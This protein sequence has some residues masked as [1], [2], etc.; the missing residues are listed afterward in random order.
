VGVA[1]AVG[2]GFGGLSGGGSCV[3]GGL[4]TAADAIALAFRKGNLGSVWH[5]CWMPDRRTILTERYAVNCFRTILT[6]LAVSFL[7][8][9][10]GDDGTGTSAQPSSDAGVEAQTDAGLDAVEES[11]PDVLA[12]AE[13]DGPLW[14]PRFDD[15]AQTIEKERKAMGAPGAAFAYIEGGEIVFAAGFGSKDPHQD[16]PVLPTTLFRIGSVTKVLTAT[17]VLQQVEAGKLDLDAPVTDV[18]PDYAFAL[19]ASWADSILLRHALDHTAGQYD[20][21]GFGS[22]DDADLEPDM[23]AYAQDYYLMSP[24]GRLW[25]YS[26]PNFSLAGLMLEKTAGVWYRDAMADSLFGPLGMSRTLFLGDEVIDDGDYASG[27][28]TNW[29]TGVGEAVATPDAYDSAFMRPAGFAYS[30]L[31]DMAAFIQFLMQGD[32]AVLSDTL[33]A[34]LSSAQV[35][36]HSYGETESYGFGLFVYDGFSLQDGYRELKLVTHGGDI[37]GFAADIYYVPELGV[38][39]VAFASADGAHFGES[40]AEALSLAPNLPA[41]VAGPAPWTFDPSV[42]S[43]YVRTY[44]DPFMVGDLIVTDENGVLKISMPELDTYGISYGATPMP[45]APDGFILEIDGVSTPLTFIRD[46][47][48]AVEYARTRFFVGEAQGA[49][50]LAGFGPVLVPERLEAA[51]ANAARTPF[52]VRP[53]QTSLYHD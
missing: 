2:A 17:A 14:E 3:G 37:P 26:N 31:Q 21:G 1:V 23:Y 34:E 53:T 9:G 48:G 35:P 7:L 38:G 43:D 16:D 6:T 36:T 44:H 33:R 41:P 27:L 20:Y 12:D 39:V 28:T 19:D 40:V 29:Q 13:T 51:L 49:Q 50:K 8:P 32:P 22:S 52:R 18:L 45:Y 24:S 11:S 42:L 46:D 5:D 15:L 47:Q 4:G 25:N 30:S 10:C